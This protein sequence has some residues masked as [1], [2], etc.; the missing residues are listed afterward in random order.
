[1]AQ[2]G[3][4]SAGNTSVFAAAIPQMLSSISTM[5]RTLHKL[6]AM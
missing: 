1:L 5:Q 6:V 4:R 3:D 2:L